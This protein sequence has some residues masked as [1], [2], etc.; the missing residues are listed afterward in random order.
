MASSIWAKVAGHVANAW[1]GTVTCKCTQF[2]VS[3]ICFKGGEEVAG[4]T[5]PLTKG[6]RGREFRVAIYQVLKALD[7]IVFCPRSLIGVG[8]MDNSDQVFLIFCIV[9]THS[10]YFYVI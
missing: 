10:M 2:F 7:K 5:S 8:H 4:S 6:I 3:Y 9:Y 1:S